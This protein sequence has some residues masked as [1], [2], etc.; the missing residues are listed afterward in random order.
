MTAETGPET[1]NLTRWEGVGKV[2]GN[3]L[4]KKATIQAVQGPL[5]ARAALGLSLSQMAALLA[6]HD[7]GHVYDRGTISRWEKPERGE[8]LPARYQMGAAARDAYRRLLADVVYLA[9]EGRLY[10]TARMG[11]RRWRFGLTAN[12]A[13]CGRPFGL[14]RST[15]KRCRRCVNGGKR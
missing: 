2:L 12:C 9:S 1:Q 14:R 8:A 15:D 10:L 13:T 3:G 4:T 5:S 6:Q 11:P 7:G